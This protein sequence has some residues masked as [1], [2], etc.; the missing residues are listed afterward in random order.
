TRDYTGCN[1]FHNV[2]Q[3]GV[4]RTLAVNW[5]TQSVYHPAQQ[6][7]ADRHFQYLAGTFDFLTLGQAQVFTQNHR[8]DRI[9]LQVQRHTEHAVLEFDHFTVHYVGQTMDAHDA[10][11]HTYDSAFIAG[12]GRGI[13][14]SDALF[15][16]LADL[17]G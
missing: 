13:Q 4:Q 5:V 11:R 15:D 7:R 8:A 16:Q 2:S 1:L 3:L 9:L 12:F 14:A 17:R 10:V 6:F